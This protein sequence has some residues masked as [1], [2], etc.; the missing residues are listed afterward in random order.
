MVGQ[1]HLVFNYLYLSK[2]NRYS[3]DE[4]GN[5]TSKRNVLHLKNNNT[6]ITK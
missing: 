6:Y 1:N 4:E 3:A 2:G 5:L